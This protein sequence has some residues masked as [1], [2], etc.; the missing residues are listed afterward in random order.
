MVILSII[1]IIFYDIIKIL[2]D[3]F[4]FAKFSDPSY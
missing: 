4:C 3:N 2:T 1:K